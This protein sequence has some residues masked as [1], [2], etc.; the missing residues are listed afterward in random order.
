MNAENI[1]EVFDK[2]F[3]QSDPFKQISDPW[4]KTA[5]QKRRLTYKNY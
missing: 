3:G 5:M 2:A 1:E 4:P